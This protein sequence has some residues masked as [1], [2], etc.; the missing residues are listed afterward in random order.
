MIQGSGRSSPVSVSVL[1]CIFTFEFQLES[2]SYMFYIS[3]FSALLGFGI[4]ETA[5]F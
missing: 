4:Y 1:V 5:I 2:S 3:G